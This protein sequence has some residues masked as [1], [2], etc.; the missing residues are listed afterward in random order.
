[1]KR[2][3]TER[4]KWVSISLIVLV[5]L[6]TG[7]FDTAVYGSDTFENED[8]AISIDMSDQ[9]LF[10]SQG[11]DQLYEPDDQSIAEYENGIESV[12]E[13]LYEES[14]NGSVY[15]YIYKRNAEGIT[16]TRYTGTESEITIPSEIDGFKVT[17]LEGTFKANR[18]ITKV[19]IP[20]GV[21][22]IGDWTFY[23][24]NNLTEVS[25]PEGC[26]R[27]GAY[28]F[29]NDSKLE[30]IVIPDSVE[31]IGTYAFTF[32]KKLKKVT[33][34]KNL[35]EIQEGVFRDDNELKEINLPNGIKKIGTD[36]FERTD[37]SEIVLPESLE[38]LGDNVFVN[39][40]LE[41]VVAGEGLRFIGLGAFGYTDKLTIWC[42]TGSVVY[43]YAIN[44]GI[45]VHSTGT[46]SA[47]ETY[48]Y[49][50]NAEGIT[51]TRYTGTESEITIPSEIDGFK[52]TALEGTFKAN[53]KITKV[54]I[55]A[56]VKE[57]GDWT[58]YACNNL[59]EVSIPEG[60]T[61]IGA[62][63]FNN[64]S[65]LEE[66][67]I[68]D[69]VESIGTYAFT[70]CKKLK[71]VTFPKNLIEIQEGVF[72]DDNE[73][74]EINLPNGIKKIG[75]DAF[76]R[77]DISEIVLPES[78][79]ELGDNVFVNANL[80]KVVAGEDL[81]FIGASAFGYTDK[82]TIWCPTGSVVYNY[83]INNGINVRSTGTASIVRV[84]G[85]EITPKT[86]DISSNESFTFSAVIM[87]GNATDKRIVWSSSN[88]NIA[89]VDE[90]GVVTGKSSG[91]TVITATTVDGGFTSSC[92]VL[93]N[94]VLPTSIKL[95]TSSK[96]ILIG[97]SF[98]LLA[99]VLPEEATDKT[100]TW[101]SYNDSIATVSTD[102]VVTGKS[103][104]TTTIKAA[105]SNGK[106]ASCTVTVSGGE[107]DIH[108]V[109][110]QKIDIKS[111]CFPDETRSISR[112]TVDN[113]S[114][115]YVSGSSLV[116]KKSGKVKVSAQVKND[117]QYTT[118]ATCDV[119]VLSRPKLKFSKPFTVIGQTMDA[120]QCF[121]TT[122]TRIED[123][124]LWESSKGDVVE[125]IDSRSGKLE[126]KG[127]GTARITAYFGK[128]GEKGTL[129]VTASVS[130][131]VPSFKNREYKIKTGQKYTLSMKN[132]TAEMNPS[133]EIEDTSV[134]TVSSQYNRRGAL[135]GKAIVEGKVYGN[136]ILTATID[137]VEYS[138]T[139]SVIAPQ[140]NKS[141]MRIKMG[142]TGKLYLKN[143]KIK[144]SDVIWTSSDPNIATIDVYGTVKGINTGTTTIYTDCGGVRNE[145]IVTVE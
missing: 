117:R 44:S 132:V 80:E 100:V 30:E 130:V 65:K 31:S 43:N 32:C 135:T 45:N 74:K 92:E 124:T 12:E 109:G 76:E 60:C 73:L 87:P 84:F 120:S 75:T 54:T 82:L 101:T 137:N 14:I 108:I 114:I 106:T 39:A 96:R 79:E 17:A 123:V 85:I 70:F 91:K 136:T 81:R 4:F 21:K 95:N 37:I 34:P 131:K 23:A 9:E 61:R 98:T 41:K 128:K 42:P 89:S 145:C 111:V 15:D 3:F 10:V 18:K 55:P 138:C 25:I 19:T 68:P 72:R 122:D 16:L 28:G 88:S 57:I 52:V 6:T 59:T 67:V 129:K 62:Y 115:A 29:N 11:D 38:E 48:Q 64:D 139:I 125:V 99:T 113:K 51:L 144:K 13:P 127:N 63:G 86:K 77:T 66:I 5:S 53:R 94:S 121:T 97:D 110:N 49:K 2:T 7:V 22:E 118:I 40:N 104:G 35:I 27:I 71:K 26:T 20:A 141:T 119:E 46:A 105:T 69:S 1:M 133:W 8:E 58:F 134:A 142:R 36:A 83:A 126:A 47:V 50:R 103:K 140:I 78:L 24:C 116:G 102:G 93:V 56:G 143:T 112:Y 107:N 33:F 90:N